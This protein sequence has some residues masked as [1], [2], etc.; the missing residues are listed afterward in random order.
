MTLQPEQNIYRLVHEAKR[1]KRNNRRPVADAFVPTL[2]DNLK[3][4]VDSES[5]TTPEETLARWG[6]TYTFDKKGFKD[7]TKWSIFSLNVGFLIN[8][9]CIKDIYPDPLKFDPPVKG[10]PDNPAHTLSEFDN[11]P[12]LEDEPEYLSQVEEHVSDREICPDMEVATELVI[13]YRQQWG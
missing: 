7:H 6:A 11:Y 10:F 4:S 1:P 12:S 2:N 3:M 5:L 13:K 9:P 8:F